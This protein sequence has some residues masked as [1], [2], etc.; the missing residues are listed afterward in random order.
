MVRDVNAQQSRIRVFLGG[1]LEAFGYRPTVYR[2]A[3]RLRLTGWVRN[4]DTGIEIEIEGQVD[5]L[6]KF[7]Y[8]L[9]AQPGLAVK[10]AGQ[11]IQRIPPVNSMWFEI[12]PSV[13]NSDP[14][15]ESQLH[16]E[17]STR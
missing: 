5:Q 6:D 4:I 15:R 14:Y 17:D 1:P 7:W 13:A 3:Q 2:L 12:L 11:T 8:E 9:K 16:M 10:L